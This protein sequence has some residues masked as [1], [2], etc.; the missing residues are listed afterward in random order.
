MKKLNPLAALLLCICV[1]NLAAQ[2]LNEVS[3]IPKPVTLELK[4]EGMCL[5]LHSVVRMK[6]L[7][8][9]W[10]TLIRVINV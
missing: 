9:R 10:K 2:T 5:E 4:K 3:I 8:K 1:G 7:Y 6:M